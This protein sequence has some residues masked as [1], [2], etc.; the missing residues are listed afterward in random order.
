[1]RGAYATGE[2]AGRPAV[3]RRPHA[4]GSAWYVS[5]MLQPEGLAAVFRD[6]LRTAG[7][8]ARDDDSVQ[9]EAV[10]RSDGTTDYTF[11]LN[12]AADPVT[13]DLPIS[14]RDLITGSEAAGEL[15][16]GA[17]GVAVIASPRSESIPFLTLVPTPRTTRATPSKEL[18]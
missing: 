8:P 17:Y 13:F 14:G 4:S 3:T 11:L 12:H 16:L 7:L 1:I 6:V 18:A 2:L 15:T 10:T 5:A 9:A